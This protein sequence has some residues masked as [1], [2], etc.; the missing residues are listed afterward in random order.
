MKPSD[1]IR[2]YVEEKISKVSKL[3]DKGGEAHVTLSVEK[4]N[5]LAAIELITDGALR[6]RAEEKSEDMYGSIDAATEKINT[7]VKRYRTKLRDLHR[8]TPMRSRELPQKIVRV[9]RSGQDDVADTPQVV[10]QETL[11]AREM[12]LDDAVLQMDLLGSDLLVFTD[13]ISHHVNVMYRLP[14]GQYGLID[15]RPPS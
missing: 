13:S 7:Q 4:H 14:D 6:I 5:H 8:D 1:P 2:E 15:A 12:S 10:R 9:N 11:V 3:L